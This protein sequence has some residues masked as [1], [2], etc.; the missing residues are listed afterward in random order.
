MRFH[1]GPI[2]QDEIPDHSWRPIREPGP[3]LIQ[4]IAL[5]IGLGVA[6]LT[7]Q[8]WKR[9]GLPPSLHFQHGQAVLFVIGL[10]LSFPLLFLVHELLHAVVHPRCGATPN[11]LIG[12]W[13][14]RML[15]YAH[16]CGLLTR[17]R[18]LAV[19]AMPFLVITV[20]PLLLAL[21]GVLPPAASPVAAWFS[22]WN[23]FFACGDYCGM[24]LIFFQVPRSAVVQNF[25][26][27]SYWKPAET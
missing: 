26:W 17:N 22:S 21:A 24:A 11:T 13:P 23:A 14:S 2:P 15:L 10:A 25:G 5:P 19:F 9:L 12:A 6:L 4:V 7:L 16:Y 8:C 20:L 18:F 27:R 1:V 3:W